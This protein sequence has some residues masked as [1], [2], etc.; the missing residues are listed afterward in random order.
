MLFFTSYIIVTIDILAAP[1][2]DNG[3]AGDRNMEEL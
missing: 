1:K 2:D 3:D